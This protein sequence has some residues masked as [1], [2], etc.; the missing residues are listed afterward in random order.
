MLQSTAVNRVVSENLPLNITVSPR[1]HFQKCC[2][3][4]SWLYAL[5][6][7]SCFSFP[8]QSFPFQFS[9]SVMSDSLRPH[10][11]QHARSPCPSPTP[12]VHWDSRPSSQW[13]HPAISSSVILFSSCAQSL[14]AS[15]SFPMS[16]LFAWGGQSTGVSALASVLPK[17]SQSWSPSEWT[18]WI[19][20]QSKGL[21]R[22]FSNT[23]V[24]KHQFFGTQPSSQ[25]NL[26]PYMTTG[27]TI[28]LTRRTFVGK[29]MFMLLSMLSRLVITF[30]P[31]SKHLLISWLQSPSAVILAS[32]KIKFSSYRTE[33]SSY[34][35]MLG[36]SPQCT[37]TELISFF[38][39]FLLTWLGWARQRYHRSCVLYI[40]LIGSPIIYFFKV[41]VRKLL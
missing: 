33:F 35:T 41:C 10:E 22:V 16:Q 6:C 13:C 2:S 4:F 38:V 39:E 8:S 40:Y 20:L 28:A 11:S 21:S 23:T 14:P 27:K 31:R 17:K 12:G 15:E 32:P 25:S 18:G 29:V 34:G 5:L 19:P 37:P 1:S 7:S 24:Q 30:L 9:H 3:D 26:H 36:N